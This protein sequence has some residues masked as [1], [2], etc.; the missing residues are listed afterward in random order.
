MKY[1]VLMEDQVNG[2]KFNFA[3]F[4]DAENETSLENLTQYGFTATDGARCAAGNKALAEFPD[5]TLV[6]VRE[7]DINEQVDRLLTAR[8]VQRVAA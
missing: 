5:A 1:R 6:Q 4:V 3:V 2:K 8:E 7:F